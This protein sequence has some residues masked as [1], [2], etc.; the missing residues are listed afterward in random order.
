M[1]TAKATM[2]SMAWRK[3]RRVLLQARPSSDCVSFFFLAGYSLSLSLFFSV[4]IFVSLLFLFDVMS[5]GSS[6]SWGRFAAQE[7][8]RSAEQ[9]ATSFQGRVDL[10]LM[11]AFLYPLPFLF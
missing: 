7:A 11:A 2:P 1:M 8:I 6:F 5:V 10:A 9:S 4:F 3:N